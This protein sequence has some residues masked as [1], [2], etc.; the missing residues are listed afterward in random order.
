MYTY[1]YIYIY[2]MIYSSYSYT[3]VHIQSTSP[4]QVRSSERLGGRQR[5]P[6]HG[7]GLVPQPCKKDGHMAVAQ[8]QWYHFGVGASPIL[9]YF[10]GDSDFH[11]GY[12]LLTHGHI[13]G[14]PSHWVGSSTGCLSWLL[15]S[16]A[17]LSLYRLSLPC[18]VSRVS[19]CWLVACLL[20]IWVL[21]PEPERERSEPL[22]AEA[23]SFEGQLL[24]RLPWNPPKAR[25]LHGEYAQHDSNGRDQD[26]VLGISQT[27]HLAKS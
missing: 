2:I 17:M 26:A 15:L 22:A 18:V 25:S 23:K 1:M 5:G 4:R 21:R 27:T 11:W 14:N 9:V 20:V 13:M 8:N 3:H 12:G 16:V 6:G 10:S 24:S 7:H 19:Y